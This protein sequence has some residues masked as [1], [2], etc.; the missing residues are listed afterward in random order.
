METIEEGFKE[1][2]LHR[3]PKYENN[4]HPKNMTKIEQ[5]NKK[6]NATLPNITSPAVV[7]TCEVRDEYPDYL[8]PVV[9]E[10]CVN[11]KLD[12]THR[13]ISEHDIENNLNT[14]KIV[15]EK[16]PD[17]HDDGDNKNKENKKR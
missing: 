15:L 1:M 16:Y 6:S 8:S 5:F 13:D 4:Y 11:K 14:T 10:Y 2:N 7:A 17:S 3:V 12:E 9:M